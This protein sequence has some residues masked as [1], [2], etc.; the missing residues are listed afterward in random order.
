MTHR[1]GRRSLFATLSLLLLA[2][3]GCSWNRTDGPFRTYLDFHG[4][5]SLLSLS[6]I[7]GIVLVTAICVTMLYRYERQLV[8]GV[9]GFT[10]LTL[11][12]LTIAVIFIALLEPVLHTEIDRERTGRIL[13]AVDVSESMDTV[14]NYATDGEKLRWAR[15]LG[16]I[17]NADIDDRLDRWQTALDEGREPEWVAPGETADPQRRGVLTDT[18][19]KNLQ[20]VFLQLAD[21]QR[22]E[23]ARRL[24]TDGKSPLIDKLAELGLLETSVFGGMIES[25]NAQDLSERIKNRD[26]NLVPFETDLSRPLSSASNSTDG[27]PIA[28]VVLVTDG[29]HNATGSENRLLARLGAVN[30]PIYPVLVGSRKF[31]KDLSFADVDH[32]LKPVTRERH[33]NVKAQLRTVGFEGQEIKVTLQPDPGTEGEPETKTVMVT[34]PVTEVEFQMTADEAGKHGYTIETEVQPGETREDNNSRHFTFSVVDD[35]PDVLLVDGEG[36]WEFRFLDN[37]LKRDEKV[38]VTEIVFDQPYMGLLQDTFFPRRLTLPT[39]LNDP[40]A[41]SP[42]EPFDMVV[43][44]DVRPNQISS[45]GWE[46]IDR[47]VREDGGTLVLLSGKRSMPLAYQNHAILQG[48]LPVEDVRALNLTGPEQE[49]PPSERGFHLTL[50]SDGER[51]RFL[52]LSDDA[53]KNRK[54]WSEL[55]GHTWGVVGRAKGEASVFSVVYPPGEKRTLETERENAIIA[56]QPAGL[57]QVI[58]IGIDSTWRW[59]QRVGDEYHHRFWAQLTEWSATFKAMDK[60]ANVSLALEQPVLQSGD[61]AVIIARWNEDFLRKFPNLRAKVAIS[62]QED[63]EHLPVMFVELTPGETRRQLEFQGRAIGLRPGD[64]R[65]ELMAED[66]VLGDSPIVGEFL[67]QE[68]ASSEL[69]D[70]SANVDLLRQIAEA[71]HG[72]L[73][74]PDELRKLPE[75]FQSVS[76]KTILRN[77]ASLWDSWYLLIAVFALLTTE[78]VLRKLNGLP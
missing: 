12:L 30:Y 15:A 40:M 58:W 26:G 39:D 31:P 11:R 37:A 72:E 41:K 78:W 24:L 14:D 32:P 17:G 77:E 8:S 59:R 6:L 62:K 68:D 65:I 9:L 44:G 73:L 27:V 52:N 20:E 67:I 53:E 55:P 63:P 25:V 13:V 43:L 47:Y 21:V 71:S 16:M 51:E 29:R 54:I 66:A 35:E 56:R 22:R 4:N 3:A 69:S 1:V 23:I 38:K 48:L 18:R 34:G 75:R 46:L 19:K 42:F 10:L 7:I 70:I 50:T 76:E 5:N 49:A 28:G 64:Y 61:E 74:M 60:N 57:G 33:P 2:C 36:R 45:I